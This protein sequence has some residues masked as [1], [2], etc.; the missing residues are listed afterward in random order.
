M[1]L[2]Q[3]RTYQPFAVILIPI[4]IVVVWFNPIIQNIQADVTIYPA[5][6]L[7]MMAQKILLPYSMLSRITGLVFILLIAFYINRLNTKFIFIPDRTYLPASFYLI[8]CC[9]LV[10]HKDF[11][12]I[13]PGV[14]L[15]LFGLERMFD[16]YKNENLSYNSFDASLLIG[17]ASLFYFNFIFLLLFIWASL[18]VLRPFNWREWVYSVLGLCVP[19]FIL[20]SIYYLINIDIHPTL[21]IIRDNFL[22]H[23]TVSLS[24]VQYIFSGFI[25]LLILFSGFHLLGN[26]GNMKILSRR[27]YNLFII[28]LLISTGIFFILKISSIEII[29]IAAFPVS[30]MFSHYFIM[31]HKSRW[32]D[33]IFDVFIISFL[34]T[35][36]LVLQ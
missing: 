17:L 28:L 18:S 32:L 5:M 30:M 29:Y 27:S 6:P 10:I 22:I 25:I 9:G 23:A 1:L 31:A 3:A 7:Y 20:V 24:K 12:P 14:I 19:Y 8:I 15:F 34:L 35:Q 36:F 13:L 33:I 4:V 2:R 16:S 21:L 11:T 26:M